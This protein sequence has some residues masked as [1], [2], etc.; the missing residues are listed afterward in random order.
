MRQNSWFGTLMATVAVGWM[1]MWLTT[2]HATAAFI[3]PAYAGSYTLSS[4]GSAP[5]VAPLYGGLTL[6]AGTTDT[7]L[8][9][10]KANTVDGTLYT[11]GVT[12]DIDGHIIGFSGVA[13]EFGPGPYNDGGL[14]YGPGGVLFASQ[15]PVN[16]LSQYKPGST[17]PDKVIDLA[18]LGVAGSHS[19]INFVPAGFGGAGSMKLVSYGGGEFYT[20]TYAPDGLGTFDITSVTYE[21]SLVGGPEGFVYVP[22]GS[23]LF[24][25]P[26]MLVSEYAAGTVGAYEVDGDGNPILG[27]RSD[28]ILGLT[29]AEGAFIDPVTGDFLF[30]TFGGGDQIFVVKGFVPPPPADVPEPS[31]LALFGLGAVGMAFRSIRRRR[32]SSAV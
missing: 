5:G 1:S 6:L 16:M 23:P 13:S 22:T 10:G 14:T 12:R 11:I 8:I 25:T 24:G 29:G 26:S 28:F 4:L 7:L 17:S 27:T 20:A 19:A 21:G 30:S 15:W 3:A 32:P 9:G 31:S 18:P 2:P